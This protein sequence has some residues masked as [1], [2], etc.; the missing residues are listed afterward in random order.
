V[1]KVIIVNIYN[2]NNKKNNDELKKKRKEVNGQTLVM[3]RIKFLVSL[4][5]QKR[6]ILQ[7]FGIV[8]VIR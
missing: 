7:F 5:E 3:T 4:V 1:Y 2:K 6:V 8:R